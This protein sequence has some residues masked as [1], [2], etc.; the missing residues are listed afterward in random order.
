MSESA[1]PKPLL[2]QPKPSK[3][4]SIKVASTCLKTKY[5]QHRWMM[6]RNQMLIT[7]FETTCKRRPFLQLVVSRLGFALMQ[8]F[9]GHI[10]NW[11]AMWGH[12]PAI[13]P[14]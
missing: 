14:K 4:R 13:G 8:K 10:T 3:E 2:K 6:L 11:L 1:A 7:V 9:P 12:V 5:A